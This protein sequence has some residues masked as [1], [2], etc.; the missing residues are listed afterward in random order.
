MLLHCLGKP[1]L[2]KDAIAVGLLQGLNEVIG[3]YCLR[4]LIIQRHQSLSS[5]ERSTKICK[6]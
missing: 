1:E 5:F 3:L 4:C 2:S 6:Y